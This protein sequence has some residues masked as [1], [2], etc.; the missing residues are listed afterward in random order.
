MKVS[1]HLKIV[2]LIFIITCGSLVVFKLVKQGYTMH[3][4]SKFK[5]EFFTKNRL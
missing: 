4:Q 5:G 1:R 2:L 3:S